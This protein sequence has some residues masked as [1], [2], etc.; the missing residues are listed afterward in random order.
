MFAGLDKA[1]CEPGCTTNSTC[2]AVR[3]LHGYAQMPTAF[4]VAKAVVSVRLGGVLDKAYSA[5]GLA[6]GN[7]LLFEDGY[8]DRDLIL[9]ML[10]HI[11]G[12]PSTLTHRLP[13]PSAIIALTS[14]VGPSHNTIAC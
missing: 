5:M 1:A 13:P 3:Q 2:T 10:Q 4:Q 7:D 11:E 12:A 14:P 6:R 9:R 8:G